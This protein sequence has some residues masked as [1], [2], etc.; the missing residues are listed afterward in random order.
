MRKAILG[1]VVLGAALSLLS[2]S[3]WGG[4]KEVVEKKVAPEITLASS[5]NS[6][7]KL[8]LAGARG[9]VVLLEFWATWCP[10]CRASIPHLQKLHDTYGKRG[11]L[12]ISV[13]NEDEKT[14]Q[15]FVKA[16]RMTFPVGID[17]GDKTMTTYGIESIPT[18]FLIDR[19]G[20]VVWEGHTMALTEKEVEK[21]LGS[22]KRL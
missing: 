21:A 17:D 5:L 4:E 2:S 13:T 19:T 10:P 9:K 18:A 12:I 16:H 3:V 8:S 22:I 14:V 1:G 6:P 15:A 11:L 7:A 20:K